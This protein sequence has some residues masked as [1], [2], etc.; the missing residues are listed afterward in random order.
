MIE[1]SN[2]SSSPLSPVITGGLVTGLCC[3]IFGQVAVA[4]PIGMSVANGTVNATQNGAQLN[5]QASHN[6]WINWQSFNIRPGET[7]SFIQPSAV[8]VVWNRILDANPSQIWG[9]LNANGYVVLM[10]QNG[11]Y[12]GPN[13]VINVGGLVVTTATPPPGPSAAGGFWQFNGAPPL[14]SIVNYGEIKAHSG[15]SLFLLSERIENH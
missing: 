7:T 2:Q 1:A 14:A 11:F 4:N 5:I 15:G 6:A 9:N 8:S 3:G 12:F 10:N 13:S